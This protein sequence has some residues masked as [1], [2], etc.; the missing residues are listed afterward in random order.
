MADQLFGVSCGFFDAVN[1]DRT[2][3]ADDMNKP[4]SRLVADGVFA[5]QDGNP[6]SDLQVFASGTGMN[7]TVAKG[8]GIFASK[9]FENPS[10]IIITVPDNNAINA[11]LDSVIAQVDK[12]TSGR[13][14]NIVYRT[15]AAAA[16]PTPPAINQTANVI[17]YRIANVIVY[18]S[19]GAINQNNITDLRGSTSCP[20]VTGLIKQVDTSTL[21][22]QFQAAYE[23]QY[24]QYT[25]D[26][27]TYIEEQRQAWE[28][29][30]HSLT[31][32]LTVSTSVVSFTS[33]YTSLTEVSHIPINIASFDAGTDVLQVYINGLL[34]TPVTDY[35]LSAD[36]EY[37]DLEEALDPEQT[38]LFVVF[39]SLIGGSIESTVSMMMRLD[40]KI[41]DF[42]ADSGW[43]PLSLAEGVTAANSG[44]TPMMRMA[45]DRVYLR[46]SIT[47]ISAANTVIA[48]LP[49]SFKPAAD[50]TYTSSSVSA[51]Y[52]ARVVTITVKADSGDILISAGTTSA[53]DAISLAGIYP[54]NYSSNMAMIYTY[55]GSVETYDD[56]PTEGVNAGDCYMV[57]TADPDHGISAGDS[58]MWDGAEWEI[59]TAAISSAAIDDII[60]SI[61]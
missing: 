37:I 29:F 46:G 15:G 57:D 32:E 48:T 40:D 39:K 23:A 27:Q 58:V 50:V 26:Y 28:D 38:V 20:W 21:W 18:P 2:Y 12:R 42:M 53:S 45:G 59:F 6:S 9:W 17:E 7:I 14:G 41:D 47:G 10:T 49:V 61:V 30:I 4:Y 44:A 54:A 35:S 3:S 52:V 24:N 8:S 19:A 13:V 31:D 56:L 55:M 43:L 25:A 34:A 11:R 22:A 60:N 33:V 16:T 51:S 36:N 5:A 1:Y